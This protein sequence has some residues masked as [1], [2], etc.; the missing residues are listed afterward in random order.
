MNSK[1]QHR[2][3]KSILNM[4]LFFALILTVAGC[5]QSIDT[6]ETPKVKEVS[7]DYYLEDN[8]R[9]IKSIEYVLK[10]EF[11]SPKKKY[12]QIVQN[13]ANITKVD[14]QR[15]LKAWNG[16]ELYNYV[17]DLYQPYFTTVG[18]EKFFAN[19]AFS[20]TLQSSNIHIKVDNISVKRSKNYNK[21]Y[22]FV[23]N[24]KY[25]KGKNPE[26]YYQVKG[27][28]KLPQDGKIEEITY[29]DDGGLLENIKKN[30]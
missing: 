11:S 22:N 19:T 3:V 1:K 9:S 16:S 21:S 10:S 13:P 4:G 18:F 27:V 23:V 26:K 6:G 17:E 29:S 24:V 30:S 14:G 28:A 15:V 20:Y 12:N 25:K 5:S 7:A 8:A 2:I